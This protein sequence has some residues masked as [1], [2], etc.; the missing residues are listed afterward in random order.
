[1]NTCND[2]N[3]RVEMTVTMKVTI[4]QALTL[5][6]MFKAWNELSSMGSSREVSFFVDGDGNFHPKCVVSYNKPEKVPELTEELE[7]K[8]F[9]KDIKGSLHFDFDSIAWHIN[10]GV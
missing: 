8:T 6:A 7:K 9:I 10:H 1:M 5:Q 2:G 3:E 4:P